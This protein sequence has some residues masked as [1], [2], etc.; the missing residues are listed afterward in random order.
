MAEGNFRA[1]WSEIPSYSEKYS[2]FTKSQGLI[3][4]YVVTAFVD[5]VIFV[6]TVVQ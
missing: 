3:Y 2:N 6:V 5:V 4:V 1:G